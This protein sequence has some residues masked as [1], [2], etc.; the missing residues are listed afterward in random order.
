VNLRKAF[1]LR[2]GTGG[3]VRSAVRGN[4]V[5]V[6]GILNPRHSRLTIPS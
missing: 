6:R 1:K 3:S 5:P 4:A 2:G